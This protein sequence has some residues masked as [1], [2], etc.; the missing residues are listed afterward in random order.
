MS[1]S[2]GNF[3]TLTDLLD[4]DRPPGLP[5][6]GAAVPLPLADGGHPRHASPTPSAALAR[7]DAFARRAADLPA[8]RARRRRCPGRVPGSA[9]TTTSTRRR[10]WPSCS[11]W[12]GRANG[13]LDAGDV[14]ARRTAGGRRPRDRRRARPGARGPRRRRRRRRRPI[15]WPS[16]TRPG[17]PRTSPAADAIRA[18]LEA[19][20]LGG[21][22]HAGGHRVHRASP[23]AAAHRL[24]ASF[25]EGIGCFARQQPHGLGSP[26]FEQSVHKKGDRH[27]GDRNS[28]VVQRRQGLRVHLA[29]RRRRR[30][31]ALQR[32]PD[33]GLPQP[34]RGP[35][36]RVRG[37]AGA[38]RA[39]RRPTSAPSRGDTAPHRVTSGG[40]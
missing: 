9:W 25:V 15:W 27:R 21:R 11:T 16:A 22:G 32:H 18:E 37:A 10:S 39:C 31:R 1:K 26:L 34:R 40:Q 14:G 13:A 8:R 20:G 3:T 30:V 36:G 29:V 7:L 4:A 5:A 24:L 33:H 28:Q 6:A 19:A 12:C 17:R 35:A 38:R 23:C 2:L